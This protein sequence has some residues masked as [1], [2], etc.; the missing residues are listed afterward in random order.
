[1]QPSLGQASQPNSTNELLL[2]KE[3]Y[4]HIFTALDLGVLLVDLDLRI[5][6]ANPALQGWLV[7]LGF[8]AHDD[9]LQGRSLADFTAVLP[10]RS[11]QAYQRVF[12]TGKTTISEETITFNGNPVEYEIRRIPITTAG[13]V[14]HILTLITPHGPRE[15]FETEL[16]T[17][18]RYLQT[19]NNITQAA[20]RSGD[21]HVIL[22]E[23]ADQLCDLFQANG[24]YMTLWDADRHEVIP[25]A[26]A[27]SKRE[28][29]PHQERSPGKDTLTR[30]VLEAGHAL[31]IA[32][33]SHSPY[34]SRSLSV[35]FNVVSALGLPL[36]NSE[37]KLGAA[38]IAYDHPHNFTPT[39]IAE[40]EQAAGQIALALTQSHLMENISRQLNELTILH[41]VAN[42]GAEA[43]SADEL[44]ERAIGL[45]E[46]A[47]NAA[48]FGVLMLEE[49]EQV[50]RPHPSYRFYG[51]PSLPNSLLNAVVPLGTGLSGAAAQTGEM[52]Y[53]P[54]VL[55]DNRYLAFF[56][57]IRSELSIPLRVSGRVIGVVNAEREHPNA[58]SP[59]DE[60][61]LQTFT[62]Q[63]ATAIEKLRLFESEYK[64]RQEAETLRESMA[65]LASD[66]DLGQVLNQILTQLHNVIPY[67]SASI[68]LQED[69]GYRLVAMTGEI[70]Q[71]STIGS[72]FSTKDQLF[73]DIKTTGKAIYLPDAQLDPRFAN[74]GD[75]AQIHGWMGV[76]IISRARILG[77]ITLD[78]ACAGE[79]GA[80][81][82]ALV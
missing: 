49:A 81:Q 69:E 6:M 73:A 74:W 45:L 28:T 14:T 16:R 80:D 31:V 51:V 82:A 78:H 58:F 65:A 23:A 48:N 7:T 20:L 47:F 43:L 26:A 52:V 71:T 21:Y 79:Y 38:L 42:A 44:I 12:D 32:N 57:N 35:A 19:L 46:E 8:I 41:A 9:P 37:H 22:Q 13:A 70:A 11:Y 72:L 27:G 17:R 67:G 66:L 60:R 34:V 25:V 36:I 62:S 24:C 75:S 40:G 4:Q 68:F 10:E 1:M 64:R 63:L 3:Q 61:L 53:A 54:D 59:A 5:L 29:Y 30:S 56:P 2:S 15:A 77:F 50:L 55:S 76:P 33:A 39:E 18:E